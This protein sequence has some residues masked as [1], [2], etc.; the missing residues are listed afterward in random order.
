MTHL[1]TSPLLVRSNKTMQAVIVD[2][3]PP[4]EKTDDSAM[5]RCLTSTHYIMLYIFVN[6]FSDS[7]IIPKK[8]LCRAES[9]TIFLWKMKNYIISDT[10]SPIC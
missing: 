5:I 9:V 4:Q 2:S 7:F 1:Y 3:Y 6:Y 10:P 8:W